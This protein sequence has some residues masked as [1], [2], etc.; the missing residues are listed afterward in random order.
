MTTLTTVGYG[1]IKGTS[2][3]ERIICIIF[4]F[5]GVLAYSFASGS[6][7]QILANYDS[8]SEKNQGKIDMLNKI[9]KENHLPSALYY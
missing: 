2:T 6:L 3:I 5:I 7:T 9:F 8:V 4:Q 1:D